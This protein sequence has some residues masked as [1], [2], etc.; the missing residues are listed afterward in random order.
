MFF[1]FVIISYLSFI[2]SLK[3]NNNI[4]NIE[5][6]NIKCNIMKVS[7]KKNNNINIADI[8]KN[9]KQNIN[10]KYS[11]K[12][13]NNFIFNKSTKVCN[14][15]YS[16]N[17]QLYID[18]LNDPT[19]VLVVVMGFAG[20]GKTFIGCQWG[21][22]EFLTGSIKKMIITR[23]LIPVSGEEIGF[24]PGG[25]NSKMEPWTRPIYDAFLEKEMITKKILDKHICDGN[26]E[27]IPLAFMRG[28][29]F[30]NSVI[31]ADEMQNSSP[32]QM[33]M[34]LT[35]IGNNSKIIISGDLEQSDIHKKLGINGLQDFIN[36]LT[37]WNI[38][39]MN[40]GSIKIIKFDK[41]DIR[42]SKITSII[43]DIYK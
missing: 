36:K 29:T 20:T 32:D 18:A 4:A 13:S 28:R 5:K 2:V 37:K 34:L 33:L 25:I 40:D 35:R 38:D 14:I 19:V 30:S 31:F 24:I 39:G 22:H 42:R 17:Q 12:D 43:L 16:K 11:L 3:M 26:I 10:Y 27:M 7:S 21:L 23:P 41:D 1:I 9:E 6:K 8:E 15:K